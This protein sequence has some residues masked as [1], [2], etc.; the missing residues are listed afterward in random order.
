MPFSSYSLPHLMF[1]MY[2][3]IT[4]AQFCLL[5]HISSI[6]HQQSTLYILPSPDSLDNEPH[7]CVIMPNE[8]R[9][10]LSWPRTSQVRSKLETYN[11]HL[12]HRSPVYPPT[13]LLPP[14][15]SVLSLRLRG[16]PGGWNPL[17]KW[18]GVSFCLIKAKPQD[19]MSTATEGPY[20]F[21]GFYG[22]SDTTVVVGDGQVRWKENVN[23][24]ELLYIGGV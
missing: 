12:L 21:E 13:H 8:C 10:Y 23:N 5:C 11:H 15:Y 24:V 19:V 20:I 14:F 2:L 16:L 7:L 1:T 4:K 6:V 3:A 22:D 17:A 9:T 18:E